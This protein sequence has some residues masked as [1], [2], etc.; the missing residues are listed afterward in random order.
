M[1]KYRVARRLTPKQLASQKINQINFCLHGIRGNL[2]TQHR[3]LIAANLHK[4]AYDISIL[5]DRLDDTIQSLKSE[6]LTLK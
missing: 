1:A 3:L 4:T 2:A 5:L 6:R